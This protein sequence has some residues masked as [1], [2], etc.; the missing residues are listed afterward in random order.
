MKKTTLPH[1]RRM[2]EYSAEAYAAQ[3]LPVLAL[4]V[5]LL[6]AALRLHHL[7]AQSLWNDEGSSYV[8]AGRD[9]I[10]IADH[11]ARD[12]H[13]PGYYWLL[14]IWRTL[15]GE[16]AFALR[17]LS[18]FA[19]VLTVACV[20]ALGRQLYHPVAGL[21]AAAFVALN[22]FSIYYSQ[23]ARMYALLGLWAAAA[24]WALVMWM[25][26]V[27]TGAPSTRW[28]AALA[29]CNLA[30]LFTHY[31]YP[32]VML[33]Q[34][35]W[36]VMWLVAFRGKWRA[37]L[38]PY[39]LLNLATLVLFAPWLPTA[40][41]QVTQWPSTGDA[42]PL[43]DAITT[44]VGWFALGVTYQ[45]SDS[46]IAVTFFLLFGL[47]C[48]PSRDG[49]Q[50]WWR[51]LLPV[52]WVAVTIAGFLAL[53]LFREANLKFLIPAQIGFALWMARG[54]WILWTL[55]PR[56]TAPIFQAAPRL[57]AIVGTFALLQ[58]QWT[59][60]DP[61]YH[62]AAFQRDDYRGIVA[63]IHA[64]PRPDDA[65]ILNAPGQFEVF[66]YY[67]RA[68]STV[69]PLPIGLTV[70]VPATQAAVREIIAQHGRIYAVLW[71]T[72]ERDPQQ[73]V[74]ST[75]NAEAFAI[76]SQ[77]Y[78]SVRLVRY[79]T[80]QALDAPVTSGEQFGEHI[81]LKSYALSLPPQSDGYR[82][83]DALQ[84][85]L[86]WR[87]ISDAPISQRYKVFVQLLNPD[88]VLVA[89]RDSE[90]AGGSAPTHTWEPS[91]LVTDNHA[92]ILPPDLPSARYTVIIGL[93]DPENPAVR[94]PVA[95]GD[96]LP[97]PSFTVHAIGD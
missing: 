14:S 25:Q 21:T 77:W 23:E 84:L 19:G 20:Y 67:D 93:Y 4:G 3:L 42:I 31:A 79:V 15:A 27:N 58:A 17:A 73:I 63:T 38:L 10:S 12:I 94:L 47:L 62:A 40:W 97:L 35:V 82:A 46:S 54:V 39:V 55:R 60:L 36:F 2:F 90:P 81:Q 75:L 92:L 43:T 72:D 45:V 96:F 32:A 61:L 30:G 83:G 88:G 26:R 1:L 66:D 76:D 80:P 59:G 87:L 56:R 28:A 13:P 53:G 50:T 65:V 95:A 89:Q 91:A 51:M 48:F 69:Y 7:D 5:I 49:A 34:G 44:I 57:A 37:A 74:E 8:Q 9:L 64:A 41:A 78:G 16:S 24:M 29:F 52:L 11:A 68:A 85:Q 86:N 6:A 70:D 18:A 33:A 71:G 22:T